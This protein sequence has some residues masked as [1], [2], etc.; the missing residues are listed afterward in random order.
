MNKIDFLDKANN[1]F[2]VIDEG[3]T[4][5]SISKSLLDDF[6]FLREESHSL[7]DFIK[8]VFLN[9]KFSNVKHVRKITDLVKNSMQCESYIKESFII[10][11]EKRSDCFLKYNIEIEPIY[12]GLKLYIVRFTNF[13][14]FD[15]AN[16]FKNPYFEKFND[17]FMDLIDVFDIGKF[18]IDC[19]T[20]KD[21]IYVDDCFVKLF[22]LKQ[23]RGYKYYLSDQLSRKGDYIVPLRETF[24]KKYDQLLNGEIKKISE[25]FEMND[26]V[27]Q[28][29]A[30]VMDRNSQGE[31]SIVGGV[32]EDITEHHNH[33]KIYHLKSIYDLAITSGGIG[34]FYYDVDIYGKEY[35][36]AN[37]IYADLIGLDSNELGLYKIS[38]FEK[39]LVKLEEDLSSD[40]DIR[41]SLQDLL[42][43]HIDG[44]ADDIVK[45]KH[46]KNGKEKYLLSSSKIDVKI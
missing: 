44:T 19:H 27:I 2:I 6:E 32:V 3:M 43:G 15:I 36:E 16:G 40:Q 10:A 4:I 35:F 11:N 45:I 37:Q 13:S 42:T 9:N 17:K 34:V 18:V 33:D 39:S 28:V 7:F 31:P 21:Q 38:D 24:M 23:S 14:R 46:L 30:I 5:K 26:K 29:S 41:K 12:L 1:F 25:V 22:G 8:E 20:S